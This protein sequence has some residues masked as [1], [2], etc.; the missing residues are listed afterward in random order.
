MIYFWIIFRFRAEWSRYYLLR[1]GN[2]VLYFISFAFSLPQNKKKHSE[3]V[4]RWQPW[5]P[6]S[7]F[8]F[9]LDSCAVSYSIQAL[10]VVWIW[11]VF[12]LIFGVYKYHIWPYIMCVTIFNSVFLSFSKYLLNNWRLSNRSSNGW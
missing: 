12:E 7:F 2:S 4:F 3:T 8:Y 6:I 5:Q 11:W 1:K 10:I 9:P